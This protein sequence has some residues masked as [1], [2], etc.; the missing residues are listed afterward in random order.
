MIISEVNYVNFRN[1]ADSTL[2]FSPGINVFYGKNGQ[3][4]TNLLELLYFLSAG[5]SFRTKKTTEVIK[6]G[7]TKCGAF[8]AYTDSIG[9]KK[10]I[11]KLL[12]GKKEFLWN[13][14]KISFDEFYGKLNAVAYI[15]EDVV[16]INGAPNYRR[17]FFDGEIAQS[18]SAFFTSVKNFNNLLKIR[19]K[20]LKERIYKNDEFS[21]YQNEFVKTGA[22][23]MKTRQ[24]YV[25]VLSSILSLNY[26]K[27][28]DNTKELE[29]V[30][31]CSLGNIKK[32][33]PEEIEAL[34]REESGRIFSREIQCGYS[35]TGPQRD[36]FLFYL[37][38]CEARTTASQGEKKSILFSLKMAEMDMILRNKKEIPVLLIDDITSYFDRDRLYSLLQ[39][40]E[41]RN[42]QIF[43][44]STEKLQI[45]AE[46]YYV[47]KGRVNPGRGCLDR[48]ADA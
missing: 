14:K 7:K 30:Y 3:G 34:L 1:L 37:N 12:E 32:K 45:S 10:Q 13:G 31:A 6:N 22:R 25:R 20:Y 33:S 19:N 39:Y 9:E 43:L 48:R 18:D 5:K 17:D 21:I 24:E 11:V 28:F 35:L 36:D 23:I 26:R 16:I 41:K 15:P 29:L 42:I 4:K 8:A 27:L 44:S 47:E 46:D 2:R 38:G 40:L